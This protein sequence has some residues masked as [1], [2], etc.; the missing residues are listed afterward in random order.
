M[1]EN[2]MRA[3]E[4]LR[5]T[6]ADIKLVEKDNLHFTVKFLGEIPDSAVDEVDKRIKS[7]ALQRMDVQVR[8]LGA[9]PDLRRPRVVWAGVSPQDAPAVTSS[10]Q[11]VI[12]ALEGV[13]Q[14][15]ERA[16]QPHITVG[17]VR[18]PRNH[19]ALVAVMRDY[20][21]REFGRTPITALKLKASSLTPKGPI[22]RDVR[23]Y[24]I[25]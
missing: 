3:E 22:Y 8:G 4:E 25:Q 18:S 24:T 19:D 14:S 13:G 10:G 21:T 15:D 1:R 17:R 20:S 7:L 9:F 23:E 12:D 11:K 5:Q 2:L 16:F 6:M